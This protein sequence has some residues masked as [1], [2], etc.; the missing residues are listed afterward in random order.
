MNI[1]QMGLDAQG[2]QNEANKLEWFRG[3]VA[4]W[5]PTEEYSDD[6]QVFYRGMTRGMAVREAAKAIRR[7]DAV[8]IVNERV[9]MLFAPEHRAQYYWKV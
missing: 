2:S 6:F 5:D 8:R 9:D 7:V 1:I 3:I 4:Q